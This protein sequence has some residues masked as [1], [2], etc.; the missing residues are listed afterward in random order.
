MLENKLVY[1]RL[2]Q[3][4]QYGR[5][6]AQ[7]FTRRRVFG[8]KHVDEQMLKAGLG[9]VYQGAGAVYGPKGLDH[10]LELEEEAKK[11]K[12]GIWSQGKKRES[13]ADYKKRTK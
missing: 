5:A 13:A 2:L 1:V 7:V 9:E 3:K 8:K 6:V 10:Y 11:K 12:L 4:D